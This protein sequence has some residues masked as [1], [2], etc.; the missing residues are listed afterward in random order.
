MFKFWFCFVAYS[1]YVSHTF[2]R[3]PK[4]SEEKNLDIKAAEFCSS[5][6]SLKERLTIAQ[7]TLLEDNAAELSGVLRREFFTMATGEHYRFPIEDQKSDK[8]HHKVAST[9]AN[10]WMTLKFAKKMDAII[11][12]VTLDIGKTIPAELDLPKLRQIS[13]RL[14]SDLRQ[15]VK[16]DPELDS[17]YVKIVGKYEENPSATEVETVIFNKCEEGVLTRWNS[18]SQFRKF[19]VHKMFLNQLNGKSKSELEEKY[20]ELAKLIVQMVA[21]SSPKVQEVYDE[22]IS[23][24]AEEF[25]RENQIYP[26]Y[27]WIHEPILGKPT[28]DITPALFKKLEENLRKFLV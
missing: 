21:N 3:V 4:N 14:Y 16:D 1:C 23:K 22:T 20:S 25:I 26:T 18:S 13:D 8:D 11:E 24:V 27:D 19:Y 10:L 6:W 7:L 12:K 17:Q 28:D 15:S 2:A 9:I 5:L